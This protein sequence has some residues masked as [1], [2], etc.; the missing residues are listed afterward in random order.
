MTRDS[1][2]GDN[3]EDERKII[4][5]LSAANEKLVESIGMLNELG[6][7]LSMSIRLDDILNLMG[8]CMKKLIAYQSFIIFLANRDNP[9]VELIPRLCDSPFKEQ[10]KNVSLKISEGALGWAVAQRKRLLLE[11]AKESKLPNVIES[12]RS[13]IIIPLIAEDTIIGAL[14]LGAAQPHCY[15]DDTLKLV[16]AIANQVSM[17]IANAELREEK[18]K[19]SFTDPVTGLCSHSHFHERLT[20]ACREFEE[21][22]KPFS[23]VM[24]D[25]DHF[26]QYN[27]TLGHLEGDKVLREIAA[28]LKSYCRESDLL[29]RY[30]GDEF[31]L[32][33]RDTDM[34]NSIKWAARIGEACQYRFHT[35]PVKL[36]A[37][38]GVANFPE[39]AM[40]KTDLLAAAEH[41]LY[42]SKRN[43]RNR[44]FAAKT[45]SAAQSPD[46]PID[47]PPEQPYPGF[48]KPPKPPP[49]MSRGHAQDLP[50]EPEE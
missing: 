44:I 26:K 24:I 45:L 5:A 33:L 18:A 31:A 21:G 34:E 16:S 39:C 50:S 13:A 6:K 41:A 9:E 49:V 47:Q 8:W 20:A 29:C 2:N 14:Y 23:L 37:S 7:S 22:R 38:I 48:V 10:F 43:G 19:L 25:V 32:I 46:H 17:A 27:D 12:E 28:L 3:S 30:G 15:D 4:K 35:Y 40:N 1:H 42:W 36:T 11:D